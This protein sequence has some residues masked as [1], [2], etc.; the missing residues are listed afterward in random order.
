GKGLILLLHGAPGVGKTSTA[1]TKER[2]ASLYS[3]PLFPITCGDLRMTHVEV[4]RNLEFNFQLAGCWGLRYLKDKGYILTLLFFLRALE[5]Y[6]G[7][8]FLTTNWAGAMDEAFRLRIHVS[9][10][11]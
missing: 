7:I 9:L 1:E 3:R 8:L 4:E 11:Y 2:I 6:R 5:Y 10:L